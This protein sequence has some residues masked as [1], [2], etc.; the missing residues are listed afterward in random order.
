MALTKIGS[1]GINTGIAFAGVTTVTTLNASDNVLAVGGTVNFNGSISIGGSV[2]IGGTLTYEDVTNV[3][4][5]GNIT[6]GSGITL[7]KDGDVSVVGFSSLGT[8]SDGGVE[9]F[10]DGTSRLSSASYGIAVNGNITI[11]EEIVHGGDTNTKIKFPANDTITFQ[12]NAAERLRIDSDGDLIHSALNKT[13]SLVST[14]NAS[15]AGTK[16]AFFGADRYDTDEEFAAIRGLLVSNSGGSGNKQ[17]GGLQFVVGSASHT[18]AMTQG[19]YVGFGTGNPRTKLHV[20]SAGSG[21]NYG[22]V[23]NLIVEDSTDSTIQILAPS[24][25]S[26]LIHFGDESNGMVG[27]IG[28]AHT[29]NSMQFTTG[30]AEAVRI[31]S[32][33]R[34]LIGIQVARNVAGG[35]NDLLQVESSGGG[36]GISVIRNSNNTSPPTID[37]GKSRGYPNTIVQENDKLGI[38]SFAGADGTDLGSIAAQITG[39]VD[40]TP[41]E[42]DMPGRI[43]FKTTADGASSTTE[44]VSIDSNGLLKVSTTGQGNGIH[45]IDSSTSSGSPNLHIRSKRSDSNGNTAFAANIYLGKN[46]TDAKVSSGIVLGTINFG[47]NHTD[48][49]EDNI[50]YS[51]SIMAAASDSFD[52]KTDMPT[53]LSFRTG[54]VGRDRDGELAG[55]SNVGTTR[56]IIK[57]DGKIGIG[58]QSPT[59]LLD[60]NGKV[61]ADNFHA[62]TDGTGYSTDAA[63]KCRILNNSNGS[64]SSL[65]GNS[66]NR[67]HF[68]FENSNGRVGEIKTNGT[69]TSYNTSSDYRLKENVVSISDGITRLKTLKP[70]RFNFKSDPSITV[71][72]FFAHEVTAVPEAV[73]G[74]KDEMAGETFYEDGDSIPEG[75]EVGDVK[76]YSTTKPEYQSIDHSK[77]TPLLTAAL[78]EAVAKIEVLE[79]KVAS[80]GG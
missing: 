44:R 35:T 25:H 43:V 75:K 79:S 73:S 39:E 69:S 64:I 61:R 71:D 24:T 34:L 5:V 36:A 52:S 27:R 29:D 55:N 65:A 48:G 42:N 9:I 16:I 50:S 41:G 17:N 7:S 72:G 2:S 46:R 12:T 3:S 38:I 8:G 57:S 1:I 18:H 80:L 54:T 67:R 53:E 45:L 4:S 15:Q 28:Y 13:L 14:Q 63:I 77:L 40:G 11:A 23:G 19:G 76:E 59:E 20:H 74:V 49:S 22:T 6:V 21:F 66:G 31:N 32:D 60:V 56:M 58:E 47:G 30:N 37:L 62:N 70:Y 51:A 68:S 33:G 78:Q 26:S 10:H